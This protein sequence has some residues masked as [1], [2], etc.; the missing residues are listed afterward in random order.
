MVNPDKL[1]RLQRN[2]ARVIQ[3]G[4]KIVKINYVVHFATGKGIL[5]I[6][7]KE[8]QLEGLTNQRETCVIT[9]LYCNH[10]N[11]F[12]IFTSC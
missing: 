10:E 2:I 1:L 5:T 11:S 6:K 3:L 7:I 9:N 4:K 8:T 12:S